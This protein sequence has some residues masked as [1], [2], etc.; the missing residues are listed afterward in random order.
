M[1]QQVH[2]R[3]LNNVEIS[4]IFSNISLFSKIADNEGIQ[5]LAHHSKFVFKK[6]GTTLMREGDKG[7]KTF[8]MINGTV[9]VHMKNMS[10]EDSVIAVLEADFEKH[11]HPIIGE[12]SLINDRVRSATIR[13]I[14]NVEL[15]IIENKTF[16]A[17]IKK[18]PYMGMHFYREMSALLQKRLEKSNKNVVALFEAY[19]DEMFTLET[20][21]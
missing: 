1:E 15:L 8:I 13:A 17:I 18:F 6:N 16:F 21:I 19:V 11:I 5:K 20:H 9:E 3:Q 12:L 10:G 2:K 4:G 7:D 14:T